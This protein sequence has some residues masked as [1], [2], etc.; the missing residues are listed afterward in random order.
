MAGVSRWGHL[1]GHT[2]P[3][4][5]T[6]GS[7]SQWDDGKEQAWERNRH[8][9]PSEHYQST[10]WSLTRKSA[11]SHHEDNLNSC[12]SSVVSIVQWAL[13]TLSQRTRTNGLV[14]GVLHTLAAHKNKW[15][16]HWVLQEQR[17]LHLVYTHL[18]STITHGLVHWVLQEQID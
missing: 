5:H 12:L 3:D 15:L 10:L 18:Q 8:R 9:V 11:M 6:D 2:G 4:S 16:V 7:S 13:H 17:L 1:R 14:H